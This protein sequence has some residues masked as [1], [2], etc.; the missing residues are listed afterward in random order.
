MSLRI[1]TEINPL[2]IF[3]LSPAT[4]Q[5]QLGSPGD[6]LPKT[7]HV[8]HFLCNVS[9]V[10]NLK[11][12]G[13]VITSSSSPTQS[14]PLPARLMD[15]KASL[16]NGDQCMQTCDLELSSKS[17]PHVRKQHHPSK[18]QRCKPHHLCLLVNVI[19]C[20]QE[21][22]QLAERKKFPSPPLYRRESTI[23]ISLEDKSQPHVNW[24]SWY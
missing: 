13:Y 5:T 7:M 18:I 9:C 1:K 14:T 8:S 3:F 10:L 24:N 15:H 2:I 21:P 22:L 4:A 6:L 12:F 11:S 17:L 19:S 20:L 16:T 23:S